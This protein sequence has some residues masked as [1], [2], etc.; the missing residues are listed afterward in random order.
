MNLE[1]HAGG[2]KF[3]IQDQAAKL[4]AAFDAVFA[5]VG[6][7]IIK[8]PVRA[9]RA[10]V[11]AESRIASARRECLARMLIK[12]EQHLRLVQSEYIGQHN[13]PYRSKMS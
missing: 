10:N 12:G 9:P 11:I 1:G 13:T 6:V 2:F 4:T 7:R 5:A 8:T 3:L